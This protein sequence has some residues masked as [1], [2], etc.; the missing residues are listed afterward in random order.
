M[1]GLTESAVNVAGDLFW[2]LS[3]ERVAGVIL[4]PD[5]VEFYYQ[6]SLFIFRRD[7][8][9][10]TYFQRRHNVNNVNREADGN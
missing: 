9:R 7:E 10:Q 1:I 4:R 6:S 8:R 3:A 2:E 5:Q